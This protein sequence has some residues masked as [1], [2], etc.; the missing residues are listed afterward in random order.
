MQT[1]FF[2]PALFSKISQDFLSSFSSHNVH[3][4]DTTSIFREQWRKFLIDFSRFLFL[5]ESL[6][7]VESDYF[8]N[9]RET[10][11]QLF[12]SLD[13]G[14]AFDEMISSLAQVSQNKFSISSSILERREDKLKLFAEISRSLESVLLSISKNTFSNLCKIFFLLPTDSTSSIPRHHQAL[15]PLPQEQQQQQQDSFSV[16]EAAVKICMS[17]FDETKKQIGEFRKQQQVSSF[18]PK[19]FLVHFQ[20]DEHCDA[21]VFEEVEIALNRMGFFRISDQAHR[22]WWM[23]L[24]PHWIDELEKSKNETRRKH[25]NE[26]GKFQHR[27][28]YSLIERFENEWRNSVSSTDW[29][30][31]Q[32]DQISSLK[33]FCREYGKES[34]FG[35]HPFIHSLRGLFHLQ[36]GLMTTNEKSSTGLAWQ[37]QIIVLMQSCANSIR[38]DQFALDSISLLYKLGLRAESLL[39]Y[40]NSSSSS[41]SDENSA[42]KKIFSEK[43]G[44]LVWRWDELSVATPSHLYALLA[45]LPPAKKL[46]GRAT[47]LFVEDP[48]RFGSSSSSS[49]TAVSKKNWQVQQR[50]VLGDVEFEKQHR[51]SG[52]GGTKFFLLLRSL[53]GIFSK[54]WRKKSSS[55]ADQNSSSSNNQ[56]K[57]KEDD[58]V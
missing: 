46:E 47:G 15:S 25:H 52:A 11:I 45:I 38:D 50:E 51:R 26:M 8:C 36:L 57:S 43:N 54:F 19:M 10:L 55:A 39:Q 49:S 6:S 16:S 1:L 42:W 7:I 17:F 41:S 23:F 24:F 14:S 37:F 27:H 3:T 18:S 31:R 2:D 20:L 13:E 4:A 9:E 12:S 44:E 34:A 30:E 22:H 48:T 56:I 5:I 53:F 58:L 33:S 29:M 32:Q 28:V 35:A 21:L 40:N